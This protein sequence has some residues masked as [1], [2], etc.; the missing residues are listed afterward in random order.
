MSSV[1]GTIVATALPTLH[2]G[3]HAPINWAS[4]TITGYQLGL[5]VAMPVAGRVSDQLGRKRVFVAAA[6][7]FTAA[8][9]A[10]GLAPDVWMLIGLRVVQALGGG[11]FMPSATGIVSDAFGAGRDRA[12]GLFSSIFPLGALAGP[13][14]GGAIIDAWSWRGVFLVNVPIG[15]VFTA[16]A[17]VHLPR[18]RP[19]GGRTDL[20]GACQ[21]GACILAAML[22]VTE[23]G[24]RGTSVLSARVLVPAAGAVAIA[25][26]FVRRADR[27]PEP[28]ISPRL[29]RGRAFAFMNAV[30][31]VWGACVI[32]LG[33]LVP[34]FAEERYHL[35]PLAAGT[36]LTSRAV[37]E[38]LVA[39]LAA[40]LLRRTGYRLP[41]LAGF[42][43]IASGLVLTVVSPP[44]LGPYSWLVVA[45]AV[46]GLGTG[47]SGPAANNATLELAP[48]DV[49]A[50][51]GLR[52]AARQAGAIVGVAAATSYA[53]RSY[54][55]AA[56]LGRAYVALAL[57][58][59]ATAPLVFGVPDRARR[60]DAVARV[61]ASQP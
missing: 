10:C 23:L 2:R 30:N 59:V 43:L 8:S 12:I 35:A 5:V 28:L 53:A 11:A 4:W 42:G 17:V 14:I 21:L 9:L 27:V 40:L 3:L 31:F 7:L 41:M 18:S 22:A 61:P 20:V 24:G 57:L 37:G 19:I 54:H 44:A 60:F 45:S 39:V 34:L 15:I 6:V 32:G 36:L 29:L 56:A 38:M 46:H 58:L 33:A 48:E 52:G 1:D 51:S 16:L 55:Q 13:V 47:G 50:I 49:G 25:V 26:W